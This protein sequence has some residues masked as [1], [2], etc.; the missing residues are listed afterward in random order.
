VWLQLRDHFLEKGVHHSTISLYPKMLQTG[1]VSHTHGVNADWSDTLAEASL[2]FAQGLIAIRKLNPKAINLLF[3]KYDGNTEI[4]TDETTLM[5]YYM[6]AE[7]AKS[8]DPLF[9]V[10]YRDAKDTAAE[11][12]MEFGYTDKAAW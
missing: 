8:E 9:K 12:K 4:I 10:N 11:K 5:P 3:E 6:D 1:A 7:A 2:I